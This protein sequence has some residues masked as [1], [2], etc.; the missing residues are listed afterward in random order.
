MCLPRSRL[1]C[2]FPKGIQGKGSSKG[3]RSAQA[4]HLGGATPNT[5]PG[6][7]LVPQQYPNHTHLGGA[8]ADHALPMDI[9]HKPKGAVPWQYPTGTLTVPTCVVPM[10]N[11][12]LPM[13]R[14]R[15]KESSSPMLKSRKTTPSSARWRMLSTSWPGE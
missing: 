1:D 12:Y 13:E 5:Y 3:R 8:H 11:T 6:S 14:S 7:T 10:P 15:S 4:A 9:S 2:N